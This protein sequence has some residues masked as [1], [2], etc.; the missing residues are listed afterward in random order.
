MGWPTSVGSRQW[1]QVPIPCFN[2]VNIQKS[3]ISMPSVASLSDKLLQLDLG[4]QA[5][6]SRGAGHLK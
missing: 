2:G 4:A 6:V 1:R 5:S 3:R